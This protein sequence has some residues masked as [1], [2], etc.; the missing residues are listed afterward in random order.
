MKSVR[1]DLAVEAKEMYEK[2]NKCKIPGTEMYSS[3]NGKIK[4]STV[5]VCDKRGE[6]AIGKPIGTYVTIDMPRNTYYDPDTMDDV[7][8]TL[9]DELSKVISLNESSTVLVAGLGNWN[10]TPDALGPKVIERI[11]ITRHLR[12]YV[13]DTID[14]GIRPVCAVAPGVLGITGIETG[15]V[16]KGIILKIKPDLLI[17]IDAL[18]SRSMSRVNSTIQIGTSG[19]SPGSGVFNRRM[20]ISEKTLGIP[21]IAIGVPTVVDAAT[22]AN[23][24]IDMVIDEMINEAD[25]GKDFYSMLKSIDKN[26]KQ[27]MIEGIL[28]PYMG[29]LM[30]TPKEIDSVIEAVS[31]IIAGGI[32]IALQPA[33]TKEDIDQYMQ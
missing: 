8:C 15:E 3:E 5:K 4:V 30:V 20:E 2:E 23:D 18:A 24:T 25:E 11:M 6:D 16:L 31:K 7:S 26:K 17:C 13:P 12:Q 33:L 9:S 22:M 29:N 19:I 27:K 21:V 32:N 14:E 10:I 1:T 28:N